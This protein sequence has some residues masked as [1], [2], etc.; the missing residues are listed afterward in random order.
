MLI[1]K[2]LYDVTDLDSAATVTDMYIFLNVGLTIVGLLLCVLNKSRR[3]EKCMRD[4]GFLYYFSSALALSCSHFVAPNNMAIWIL[5]ELY[6]KKLFSAGEH[7]LLLEVL[8]VYCW[9]K[10]VSLYK[11]FFPLFRAHLCLRNSFLL[12]SSKYPSDYFPCLYIRGWWIRDNTH[13]DG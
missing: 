5:Q 1:C 7:F 13:G 11:I 10:D 12:G 4:L 3:C 9:A 2:F 8:F 6:K